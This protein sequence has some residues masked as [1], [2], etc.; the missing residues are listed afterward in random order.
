MMMTRVERWQWRWREMGGLERYLIEST[1]LDIWSDVGR[2]IDVVGRR[3]GGR[4]TWGFLLRDPMSELKNR[5][6]GVELWQR[7]QVWIRSVSGAFDTFEQRCWV[8]CGLHGFGLRK[9]IRSREVD[10]E[11]SACEWWLESHKGVRSASESLSREVSRLCL[12]LASE[13]QGLGGGRR[14]RKGGR[15]WSQKIWQKRIS[16]GR[17]NR[18]ES[19]WEV[20][21]G[22][23]MSMSVNGNGDVMILSRSI[24][25]EQ[26]WKSDYHGLKTNENKKIHTLSYIVA[27]NKTIFGGFVELL[28]LWSSW[29]ILICP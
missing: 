8:G 14:T 23:S 29:N 19:C 10:L 26:G 13:E 7:A 17:F 18:V 22:W 6:S 12:A 5:E 9:K 28:K 25:V 4:E 20:K 2:E 21:L 1:R 24:S 16:G 15:V 3:V 27:V 11:S